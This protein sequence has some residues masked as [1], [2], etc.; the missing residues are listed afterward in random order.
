MRNKL[1]FAALVFMGFSA[2]S[3]SPQT[4][5]GI[6][7]Q[8]NLDYDIVAGVVQVGNSV[9]F[10]DETG[11]IYNVWMDTGNLRWFRTLSNQNIVLLYAA[12]IAYNDCLFVISTNS[13]S[14]D[15]ILRKYDAADGG[16]ISQTNLP[17]LPSANYFTYTNSSLQTI[18]LLHS[19]TDVVKVV[20]DGTSFTI[21][22]YYSI[23]FNLTDIR[24]IAYG[25]GN[26]YLFDFDGTIVKTDLEFSSA[27]AEQ[28]PSNIYGAAAYF[29]FNQKLYIGTSTGLIVYN[30]VTMAHLT[31]EDITS[32]EVK[33][34]PLYI[35]PIYK[36]LYVGYSKFNNPGIGKY[37]ITSALS[38]KWFY[39]SFDPITYSPVYYSEML[40][41]I[42]AIDDYGSINIV[43][44]QTGALLFNKYLGV[45][46]HPYLKW[47]KD[48]YGKTVYIPVNNP[49][50]V[51]CYSLDY[52][53]SQQN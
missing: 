10:A 2:C 33:Y 17:I 48:Y 8:Y 49:S 34:S 20:M 14:S 25:D 36:M 11:N 27:S 42:A 46:T 50:R 26:F 37:D 41:V 22:P 47:A 39:K 44:A 7:W 29:S 3:L 19:K 43:N 1:I 23:D 53:V 30:A 52:A 35:N 28:L 38:Q 6:V 13:G 31:E 4:E 18:L 24:T 45:I 40:D 32:M 12:E 21:T 15:S 5:E 51:F 16:L 9:F